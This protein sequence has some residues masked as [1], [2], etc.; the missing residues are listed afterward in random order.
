[1]KIIIAGSGKVGTTLALRLSQEG[2]A[3]TL[4][5]SNHEV[6]ENICEQ[7]D[8]MGVQGNCA[9][10]PVLQ[11]AGIQDADLLIAAGIKA[12]WC[13]A[14]THLDVPDGILVQ[15]ENMATSFAVLSMHLQAQM[16]EK[17]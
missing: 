1:M 8:A 7:C 6:L 2:N 4:I 15:Y 3:I 17:K 14:P 10:M 12:I 5:D 13:F 9:S 16:K 11:Q